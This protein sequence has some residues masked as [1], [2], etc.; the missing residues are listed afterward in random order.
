MKS[1][2]PNT[3]AISAVYAS[4]IGK[5]LSYLK[6]LLEN[7]KSQILCNIFFYV[8]IYPKVPVTFVG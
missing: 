2:K 6:F 4:T 8:K 1:I 7:I 3:L 5:Y